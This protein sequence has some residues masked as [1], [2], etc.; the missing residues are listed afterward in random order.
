M[1]FT[2]DGYDKP[3]WLKMS[4]EE[5]TTPKEGRVC[6]LGRWWAVTEQNEVLFFKRH[7]SPQCNYNVEVMKSIHPEAR[8]VFVP[9]A[10]VPFNVNDYC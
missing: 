1:S 8:H 10:Y 4:L 2:S 7:T 6:R 9:V 5:L 3:H